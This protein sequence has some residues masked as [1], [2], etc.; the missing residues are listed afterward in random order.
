MCLI[1]QLEH[2]DGTQ[3]PTHNYIAFTAKLTIIGFLADMYAL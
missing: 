1:A 3:L 2:T